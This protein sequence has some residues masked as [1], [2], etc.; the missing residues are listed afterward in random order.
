MLVILTSLYVVERLVNNPFFVALRCLL[1][2]LTQEA[3]GVACNKNKRNPE[4]KF[5]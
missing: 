4:P 2:Q 3:I 5:P 1:T